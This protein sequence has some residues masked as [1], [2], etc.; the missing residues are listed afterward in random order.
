MW[1]RMPTNFTISDGQVHVWRIDL[2]QPAECVHRQE[3]YL[4]GDE[5]IRSSGFR[6]ARDRDHFICCRGAVRSI[7][8][9]YL[10]LAPSSLEFRLGPKGKPML[11][12]AAKSSALQFN[13]SHSHGLALLAIAWKR[14]VGIDLEKIQQLSGA[15]RIV[16]RFFSPREASEYRRLAEG[17]KHEAFFRVWTRKE[18]FLKATGEGM[19]TSMDWFD[20]S[21]VPGDPPRLLS[22]VG[23]PEEAG[24]WSL[25]DLVP[26]PGYAASLALECLDLA[27]LGYQWDFGP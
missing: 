21:L 20:V 17:E 18:A 10:N 15:D 8:G 23:R 26:Q 7:L 22:V 2:A 4:S 24:R 3:R 14:R 13:V 19:T 16:D 1:E 5:V 11:D 25:L 12:G 6:F 27:W 9:L